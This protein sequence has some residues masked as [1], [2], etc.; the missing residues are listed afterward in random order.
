MTE[1]E[2][3]RRGER[4]KVDD[5]EIS[6][7]IFIRPNCAANSTIRRCTMRNGDRN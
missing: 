7:Y 6:K 4:Y 2:K 5:E 3:L 1:I